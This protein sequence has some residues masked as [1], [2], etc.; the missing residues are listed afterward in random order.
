MELVICAVRAGNRILKILAGILILLMLFFGGWSLWENFQISR[1]A[2]SGGRLLQYKPAS[3]GGQ[4]TYSLDELKK[5]NPDTRGWLTIEGTHIDYPVVQGEDDMKY[6][7]TNVFGEFALTGSIFLSCLNSP[8]FSDPYNLIYGHHMDNGGMF[9][10]VMEFLDSEYFE[11]H[12]EGTLVLPERSFHIVL[13]AC[14]ETDA[15]DPLVYHPGPEY[16][17]E[18]LLEELKSHALVY[19]DI[20]VSSSDRIV[21]MSTCVDAQTDGRVVLFGKLE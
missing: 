3:D 6:V 4:E 18:T 16:Q 15:Y 17:T 10:D 20:G 9:G 2:F 14:L 5:L 8:D 7:N 13:F 19:R 12:T 11:K 21:G 1:Q